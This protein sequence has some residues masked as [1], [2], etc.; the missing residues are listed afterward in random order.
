MK[1]SIYL[2]PTFR[3][4]PRPGYQEAVK[5]HLFNTREVFFTDPHTPR[6]LHCETEQRFRR[7]CVAS[8]I[9]AFRPFATS[10]SYVLISRS[11]VCDGEVP[12]RQTIPKNGT[13]PRCGEAARQI[14]Y[15]LIQP[16]SS[17]IQP[18]LPRAADGETACAE[19]G[20]CIG[21]QQQGG[22]T[23]F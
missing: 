13:L 15:I 14:R 8:H 10:A 18:P 6:N 3:F 16:V 7:L 1:Q 9:T 17:P 2:Q 12:H 11:N 4:I 21:A 23:A 19:G 5:P 22:A 20:M